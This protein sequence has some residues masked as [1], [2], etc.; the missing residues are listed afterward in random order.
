M[1]VSADLLLDA[2]HVIPHNFFSLLIADITFTC[3][4]LL[5]EGWE[6]QFDVFPHMVYFMSSLNETCRSSFI[7]PFVIYK[8]NKVYIT[9]F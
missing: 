2:L 9:Y 1:T 5:C 3:R 4:H 6:R 7:T 8:E